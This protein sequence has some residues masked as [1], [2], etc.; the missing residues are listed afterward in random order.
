MPFDLSIVQIVIVLVIALLVFGPARLPE[1]ARGV[2]RGVQEFKDALSTDAPRR[3]SPPASQRA[4]IGAPQPS[5]DGA[6][7][8]PE[9]MTASQPAPAPA[10]AGDTFVRRGDDQPAPPPA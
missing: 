1:I 5:P 4:V 10:P 8:S 9:P 7:A 3:S 6:P 2:G